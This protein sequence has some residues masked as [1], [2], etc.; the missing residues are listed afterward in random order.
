M[1]NLLAIYVHMAI[2]GQE[3]LAIHAPILI[4]TA[5]LVKID[6]LALRVFFQIKSKMGVNHAELQLLI[7]R[8]LI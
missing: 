8:S 2:I 3:Q 6:K 5:S 4:L 1:T 7:V